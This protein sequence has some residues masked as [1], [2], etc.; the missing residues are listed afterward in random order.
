MAKGY[1]YESLYHH[2]PSRWWSPWFLLNPQVNHFFKPGTTD[3]QGGTMME[4]VVAPKKR[5]R[6]KERDTLLPATIKWAQ[7]CHKKILKEF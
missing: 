6:K 4:R 5:E 1:A 7:K 2:L 3:C